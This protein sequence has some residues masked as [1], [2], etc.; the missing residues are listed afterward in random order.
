MELNAEEQA[1]VETVRDFVDREVRPVA[2]DL[3]HAN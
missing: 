2:R 1:V 3:D